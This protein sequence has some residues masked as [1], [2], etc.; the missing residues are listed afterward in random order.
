M[1]KIVLET[2]GFVKD[3]DTL[4]KFIQTFDR[5]RILAMGFE[6]W[7]QLERSY[8]LSIPEPSMVPHGK[9]SD[10]HFVISIVVEDNLTMLPDM[11]L[12]PENMLDVFYETVYKS[13]LIGYME[14]ETQIQTMELNDFEISTCYIEGWLGDDLVIGFRRS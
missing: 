14:I 6:V 11:D 10:T 8:S 1:S 12:V 9:G 4:F 5:K 3:L 2:A 7:S 13:V